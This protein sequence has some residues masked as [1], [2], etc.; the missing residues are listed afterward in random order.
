MSF[1]IKRT[2]EQGH[3]KACLAK[4][5]QIAIQGWIDAP[6]VDAHDFRSYA[7][8]NGPLSDADEW[9]TVGA[10]ECICEPIA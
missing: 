1:A 2:P 3:D 6:D 8:D 7:Q 9:L 10:V 4:T 5:M